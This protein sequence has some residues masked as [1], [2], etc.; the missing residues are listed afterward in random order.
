M[1]IPLIQNIEGTPGE[2]SVGGTG[3]MLMM[4]IG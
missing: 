1:L 3:K 2:P 4:G